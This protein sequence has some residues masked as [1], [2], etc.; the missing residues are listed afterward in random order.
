MT[1]T[2]KLPYPGLDDR[3]VRIFVPAHEDGET[4]PVV[5]MTDGQTA[6][7]RLPHELGCWSTHAAV[8]EERKNYGRGAIIVG[9]HNDLG[10]A[11]RASELTPTTLGKLQIPEEILKMSPPTGEVFDSFVVNTV[12]PFVESRFPVKKGR[13]N[14]AF[15]GSSSGGVA[16]LHIVMEHQDLFSMAGVFSPA[17][18]IFDPIEATNWFLS[19]MGDDLPF[20]YIYSGA[21]GDMESAICGCAQYLGNA[22]D[23]HYPKELHKTLIIPQYPHHESAWSQVFKDML[24]IFLDRCE[25]SAPAAG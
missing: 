23:N 13:E 22:L 19:K 10:P 2:V 1:I 18:M 16:S 3:M 8:Q 12:M 14:T 7:E 20:I 4:F 9:I 11:Q 21:F 5:Y 17:L 6:F 24:H 15:C 25:G